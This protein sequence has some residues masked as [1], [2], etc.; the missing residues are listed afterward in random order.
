[1]PDAF[2]IEYT[3]GQNLIV[4][5]AYADLLRSMHLD[6]SD[7]LWEYS[8]GHTEG[9]MVKKI[10]ERDVIRVKIP[11]SSG[12]R[13]FFIKRHHPGYAGLKQ[14]RMFSGRILSEG[15]N[16][17]FHICQFR[18]HGLAAVTPVAAGECS[19]GR[20]F[21][22]TEDFSPFVSLENLLAH[23][24]EFRERMR[25][26][27]QRKTLLAEIARYARKM[28]DAGLNHCDFNADHILIHY[29][30]NSDRPAVAVYDLQRIRQR[31]V[32]RFRWVIKSLAELG[33]SLPDEF[34]N[35][36]D[37]KSL[38]LL[39]KGKKEPGLWDHM[40]LLWI[41]RKMERIR[42]HTQKIMGRH[43]KNNDLITQGETE[44]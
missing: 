26:P 3:E 5:R 30:G 33:F 10:R 36:N 24:P 27:D 31:K 32:F 39:Y 25:N 2:P 37:R 42:S 15:R 38:F 22:V 17:F 20:A 1:M 7:A 40:Q 12:Y 9:C 8:D 29:D 23:S 19:G 44:K 14:W 43:R 6:F 4:N 35:E 13:Y 28:H 41:R 34:F 16:E 11:D 18:N 21:I